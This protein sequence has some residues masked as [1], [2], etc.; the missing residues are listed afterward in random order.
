MA[1]L[2]QEILMVV[3]TNYLLS[4][5][6]FQHLFFFWLII[7]FLNFFYKLIYICSLKIPPNFMASISQ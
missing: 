1:N 2:T 5:S 3:Y 7:P 4:V 6:F